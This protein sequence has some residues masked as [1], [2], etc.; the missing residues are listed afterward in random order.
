LK[1]PRLTSAATTAAELETEAR[2][3][4]VADF[5][6]KSPSRLLKK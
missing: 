1:T 6:T 2:Q 4:E 5:L 3:G